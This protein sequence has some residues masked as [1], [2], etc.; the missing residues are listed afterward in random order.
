MTRQKRDRKQVLHSKQSLHSSLYITVVAEIKGQGVITYP[1][2][3]SNFEGIEEKTEAER[4]H[5]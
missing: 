3:S 5:S 2:T 4:D 1:F